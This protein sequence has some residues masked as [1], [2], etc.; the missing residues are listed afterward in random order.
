MDSPVTTYELSPIRESSLSKYK[1]EFCEKLIS[2]MARGYSFHSFGGVVRVSRPTLDNWLNVH[3]EFKEA[4]QV[5]ELCLLYELE[6]ISHEAMIGGVEQFNTG[7]WVFKMKNLCGWRDK[8][9]LEVGE[10][11]V[12]KVILNNMNITS[13]TRSTIDI[14]GVIQE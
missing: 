6:K 1:P 10:K 14:E 2:H 5:G 3:P 9:D 4:K 7:V 8:V 13:A 11:P 12:K